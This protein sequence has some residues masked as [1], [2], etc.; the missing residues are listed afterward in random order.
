MAGQSTEPK[1]N[2]FYRPLIDK[3]PSD[4]STVLSAVTGTE[5]ICNAARQDTNILTSDQQLHRVMVGRILP[6]R[7]LLDCNHQFH[8]LK[9]CIG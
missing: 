6:G 2:M 3:T 8:V 1:T 7:I 5:R 4:Q 9:A